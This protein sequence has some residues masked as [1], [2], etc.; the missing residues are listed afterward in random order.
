MTIP[1]LSVV[2]PVWNRPRIVCEAIDSALAQRPG[3]VEVIVVDDASTDGTADHVARVY[4]SRVRLL[5]MPRNGGTA[6]ARN[7]GASAAT[8]MLLSF[9]DS[10]D[11]FL[12]GKL[13]AELRVLETF[14]G[15][16][17]VITDNLGFVEGVPQ[18]LSR[19]AAIGLLEAT[20]GEPRWVHDCRW[21]WTNSYNGVSSC[22]M[23]LRRSA[24]GRIGRPLFAEDLASFEDWEFELRLYDR[25]RVVALPEVWSWVRRFDDGTRGNRGVPGTPRTPEQ[26]LELQRDRLK[27]MDRAEWQNALR[28]DLREEFE[29]CRRDI[30]AEL[31]GTS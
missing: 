8:G 5:R 2:I 6:A 28:D 17:A 21:L 3:E 31:A 20:G 4:G 25:L 7:A 24:A 10:D 30:A 9:L 27:I 15:A 13:D 22:G 1:L 29:R 26:H 14:E 23:T 12:P 16:E 18:P 11:I 19:F